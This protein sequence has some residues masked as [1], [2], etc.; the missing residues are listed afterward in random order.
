MLLL[1]GTTLKVAEDVLGCP[2]RKHRD[3]FDEN[4]PL[5]KPLLTHLHDVHLQAIEDKG[6]VEK[7]NA[8]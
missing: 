7:A 5:I 4:D 6:N 2:D 8:Y 3:W 1:I